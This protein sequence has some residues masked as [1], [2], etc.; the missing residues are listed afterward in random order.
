MAAALPSAAGGGWSGGAAAAGGAPARLEGVNN[1][2]SALK[3]RAGLAGAPQHQSTPAQRDAERAAAEQKAAQQQ[4]AAAAAAEQRRLHREGSAEQLQAFEARVT[5]EQ[6][7]Q[8]RAAERA[9]HEDDG[10]GA[11]TMGAMNET[12]AYEAG[13]WNS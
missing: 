5:E 6:R 4:A 10:D 9:A 1:Y 7:A 13:S 11:D 12:A 2:S 3:A 8:Q